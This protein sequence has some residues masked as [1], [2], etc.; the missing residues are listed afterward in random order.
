MSLETIQAKLELRE[1][2]DAYA[3]LTD[4]KRISDQMLLFTPDTQFKVYMSDQLVAN[5]SGTAQLE[6]EFNGHVSLVKRYFSLNGQHVVNVDGDTATG[7]VFS[8]IKMLRDGEEG[9]EV[10]TDYSVQ[11]HDVYV[12]Q[13]EKWLIKERTSKYIFVEAKV[14]QS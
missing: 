3:T 10:L 8:H 2:V 11:Y 1:L 9:T 14:L 13:N 5:V 12:R 4:E 6:E 7:V